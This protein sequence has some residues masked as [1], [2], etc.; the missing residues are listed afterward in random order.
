MVFKIVEAGV[1]IGFYS[2]ICFFWNQQSTNDAHHLKTLG[3]SVC[4]MLL[5]SLH[6]I[7]P[8]IHR[9]AAETTDTTEQSQVYR[10]KSDPGLWCSLLIP[11]AFTTNL[12]LQKEVDNMPVMLAMVSVVL[13]LVHFN[14]SSITQLTCAG[15]LYWF[16][17][18]FLSKGRPEQIVFVLLCVVVYILL[19]KIPAVF[20]KSFTEGELAVCLQTLIIPLYP[21]LVISYK[22]LKKG[23]QS[24]SL[25]LSLSIPLLAYVGVLSGTVFICVIRIN[26]S[27]LRFVLSYGLAAVAVLLPILI[28]LFG[29]PLPYR[30]IFLFLTQS[31]ARVYLLGWWSFLVL[32]SLCIT[33]INQN[34]KTS[35]SRSTS[36][37]K[38]FHFLVL[39][40]Y[41]PGLIYD[42]TLLFAASWV[43]LGCMIIAETLR[44]LEVPVFGPFFHKCYSVF[45]DSQDEGRLVLTPIYLLC[46]LSFP[47][48][49]H[50]YQWC[51]FSDVLPLFAGVL[52]IGVGDT[53]ASIVGSAFGKHKIFGSQ[54]SI[55]GTV[56]SIIFQL[57]FIFMLG[58]FI[59]GGVLHNH[60]LSVAGI[61]AVTSLLEATTSQIDNHVLPLFM[62]NLLITLKS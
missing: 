42:A 31:Q 35:K 43:A 33:V 54:K 51:D 2:Y 9:K 13:V 5:M 45:L 21:V 6:Q 28:K 14:P 44:L 26:N 58:H 48:W 56:A 52:S 49:I 39:G 7:V 61:I 32:V 57:I 29:T 22:A 41:V 19:G 59:P 38:V 1:I 8:V 10:S 17:E 34:N 36:V 16:R 15:L 20:P 18:D 60:F 47:L 3:C 40:V 4:L 24:I 55:E 27:G 62:Y 11:L 23:V 50:T 53:M 25:P 30:A 37:R 46:G 12:F